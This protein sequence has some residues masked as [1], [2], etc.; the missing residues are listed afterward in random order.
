MPDLTHVISVE[1][2]MVD[3]NVPH[4]DHPVG[5]AAAQ[6]KTTRHD[7]KARHRKGDQDEGEEPIM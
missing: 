6:E 4:I 5:Q 2:R 1:L 7:T 3:G